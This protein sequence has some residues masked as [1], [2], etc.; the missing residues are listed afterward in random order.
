MST[1]IRILRNHADEILGRYRNT[2]FVESERERKILDVA[3]CLMI[4]CGR[5]D[6]TMT[7]LSGAMLMSLPTIRRHFA[8]MDELLGAILLRHLK[9]LESAVAKISP[10]DQDC[11]PAK[12]AAY[13]AFTR[14]G[15]GAHTDIHH[16]LLREGPSL[17]PDVGGTVED[18]RRALAVCLFGAGAPRIALALL[19]S[20]DLDAVGIESMLGALEAVLRPAPHAADPV[21]SPVIPLPRPPEPE[22]APAAQTGPHFRP[23]RP[24]KGIAEAAAPDLATWSRRQPA[25]P[26]AT[27][28]ARAGPG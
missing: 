12:R 3:E 21:A 7:A 6:I 1:P 5:G 4:R 2:S 26:R 20:L 24:L 10:D 15:Y 17:P 23:R 9:R 16:L 27:A 25:P 11:G 14:T 28:E 18:T 22:P 19:D 8:D 13:F